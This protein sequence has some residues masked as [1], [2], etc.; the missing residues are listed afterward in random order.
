MDKYNAENSTYRSRTQKNRDLYESVRN[1]NLSAFDVNSNVSVIEDNAKTV[2]ISHVNE[3]LDDIYKDNT[4]RRKSID[5]SEIPTTE[6]VK[7][8][9]IDTREYDINAILE[10]AR[11][12]KNVDYNRER[13][14][15]VREAEKD[16][17][18][19]LDISR[20]IN[21]ENEY[22]AKR[23]KE[24]QELTDLI[25]TIT[26]IEKINKDKY[27]KESSES[28]DLLLDLADDNTEEAND[29]ITAQ[30]E[31]VLDEE[32][33]KQRIMQELIEKEP[34]KKEEIEKTL[35]SSD[36]KIERT[37]SKLNIDMDKYEDFSDVSKKDTVSF[38]IKIIIF[39]IIIAL[40]IGAVFILNNILGLGLFG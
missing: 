23:Q 5:I 1:S 11:I 27:D 15:K 17:L 4:P 18:T 6:I 12:G 39:M 8:D 22:K 7:E 38:I 9:I 32:T 34:E 35:E 19:N 30:S 2:S 33:I 13:L 25:N 29:K 26:Q 14:K 37:L 10:K 21:E 16:I 28:L 36:E 20:K 40:I 3:L 24:E 31:N